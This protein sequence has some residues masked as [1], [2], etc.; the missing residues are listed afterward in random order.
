MTKFQVKVPRNPNTTVNSNSIA[1]RDKRT[2]VAESTVTIVEL[3]TICIFTS[4]RNCSKERFLRQKV[5][6]CN[7]WH[8]LPYI[9]NGHY[10]YFHIVSF[11]GAIC[12]YIHIYISI[13]IIQKKSC[14]HTIKSL[15][16]MVS[17]SSQ[18]RQKFIFHSL[19]KNSRIGSKIFL[20]F[21]HH[22]A[23]LT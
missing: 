23:S 14:C 2:A 11:Y 8:E 1:S 9:S 15:C 7:A 20:C 17:T 13:Y 21:L 12:Q 19:V 18:N 10:W 16:W 22:H 5:Q 4:N 3:R 6:Y